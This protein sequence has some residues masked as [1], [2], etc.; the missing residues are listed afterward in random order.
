MAGV[1][2]NL[3][4]AIKPLRCK[5][6][7]FVYLYFC[8]FVFLYICIFVFCIFVFLYI[9]VFLCLKSVCVYD[10]SQHTDTPLLGFV[11]V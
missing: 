5:V 6:S 10:V 11:F 4:Q 2:S 9:F 3:L 7:V 1:L 8:I